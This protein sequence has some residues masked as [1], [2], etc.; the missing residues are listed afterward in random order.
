V[1]GYHHTVPVRLVR[2]AAKGLSPLQE[3]LA[4]TLR[5]GLSGLSPPLA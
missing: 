1:E 5:H 3:A 4:A 2:R